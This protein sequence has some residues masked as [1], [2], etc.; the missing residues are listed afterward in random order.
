MQQQVMAN[1]HQQT[2]NGNGDTNST[3]NQNNNPCL[4][5]TN[6]SPLFMQNSPLAFLAAN[7]QLQN[8]AGEFNNLFKKSNN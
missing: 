6:G 7:A 8:G 1:L 3:A 5:D 4:I 2:T